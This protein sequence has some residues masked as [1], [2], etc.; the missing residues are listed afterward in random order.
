MVDQTWMSDGLANSAK[1]RLSEWSMF[2][3]DRESAVPLFRQIYGRVRGAISAGGLRPGDRLPSARSLAAQIGTARG[4][5]EAAYSMLSG[6]GWIIHRGAA[7]TV[8]APGIAALPPQPQPRG[9]PKSRSPESAPCPAPFQMGL[10]ALD[11]FPRKVWAGLGG[12]GGG[13]G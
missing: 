12:R 7:G 8:V 10:P 2:D 9:R 5:V 1:N 13:G 4:T 3:I 11:A 6:E